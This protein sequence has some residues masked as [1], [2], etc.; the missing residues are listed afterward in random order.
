MCNISVIIPI[1]N[2]QKFISKC[3]DSVIN[4]T[5]P[6]SCFEIICIDDGSTDKTSQI[7]A[8]YALKH[9]NITILSQTNQGQGPARNAGVS[10]A[11]GEYIKFLDADDY[12]HPNTLQIL[13]DTAEQ[14][15]ADIVV[16]KALCT[17]EYCQQFSQLTI[18]NH[19]VGCY[20]K[21]EIEKMDF[22]NN[23]CSPVLWDKLIKVNIAKTYLS[24]ALKRGQDFVTLLKYIS[25]CKS[26]CFIE[27][28]LY[29]YRHHNASVMS[30][31]ESR[32]TI[33]S[34]FITENFAIEVMR[35]YFSETK[36]YLYYC[37]RIKLEWSKKLR[38][39]S[40]LLYTNDIEHIKNFIASLP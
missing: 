8:E 14:T 19:L 7:L 30:E 40:G 6:N 4:Q 34:D 20:T 17:D 16:C 21:K 37:Q 11:R 38:N 1:Y 24:P 27:D 23:I 9:T 5:F 22:F 29:Y 13:Y 28:R 15:H 35:T 26:I 3:L 36:A 10:I 31:I 2:S 33:M 25:L 32:K 12:L 18:W 39:K